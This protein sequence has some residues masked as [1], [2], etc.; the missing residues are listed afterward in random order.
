MKLMALIAVACFLT[1]CATPQEKAAREQRAAQKVAQCKATGGR[2][3][4][5]LFSSS[6]LRYCI[7]TEQDARSLQLAS[8]CMAGGNIPAMDQFTEL[9]EKCEAPKAPRQPVDYSS[10]NESL[11]DMQDNL[12]EQR[13]RSAPTYTSC[14][15][16]SRGYTQCTSR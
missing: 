16:D 11:Q 6:R 4:F 5:H 13:I 3:V 12:R 1:G 7:S 15:T 10:V 2:V 9:F 14:Y 8:A